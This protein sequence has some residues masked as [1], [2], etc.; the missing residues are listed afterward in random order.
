MKLQF[1]GEI[2]NQGT[3]KAEIVRAANCTHR[4][5]DQHCHSRYELIFVLEGSI[6]LNIEGE[7][8]L[9][10]E[11]SG[12]IIAP[13]KYHIVTGNNDAYHRLILAFDQDFVP[14]Q[15]RQ[16]FFDSIR[17]YS[18]FSSEQVSERFRKYAAVLERTNS[19]YAPLL[20]AI[21][22]EA[23]YG[24][25]LDNPAHAEK[26]DS[27]RTD[28]LK[29][30][31][32]FIDNNLDKDILLKDVANCI[33]M[34]ESAV[35][36]LFKDEMSVS[37]KQYILQKKMTYAKNLLNHGMS[38]S[39]VATACGYKNYASFYKMFLKIMG[40]SPAKFTPDQ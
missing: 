36:H 34:S 11:N 28:K 19:I 18:V 25:A 24:L 16:P 12:V 2:M 23:V 27:K 9:L 33:Y 32:S 13:L 8:F 20:D 37:L 3:F 10:E 22:T 1:G 38:P 29:R 39:E 4:I 35:C 40:K 15:I 30:I 31:I 17:D 21:L 5:Y 7:H 26:T 14:L 6:Q